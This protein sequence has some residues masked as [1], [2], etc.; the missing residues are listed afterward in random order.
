[1]EILIA[2]V[3]SVVLFLVFRVFVLWYWRI[4]EMADTLSEINKNI[5][6]LAGE[7]VATKAQESTGADSLENSY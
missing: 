7:A 6:K 5:A 4:N 2:L 1:M 3:V